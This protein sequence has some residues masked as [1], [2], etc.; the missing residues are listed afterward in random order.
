M[1]IEKWQLIPLYIGG[2]DWG[3]GHLT[4]IVGTGD[5][6][7]RTFVHFFSN[8]RGLLRSLRRGGGECSP[9]ELTRTLGRI[10]FHHSKVNKP[11]P[12]V[13]NYGKCSKFISNYSESMRSNNVS[14]FMSPQTLGVNILSHC[15]F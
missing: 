2:M 6:Q 15:I 14:Q 12:A 13:T 11:K 10:S 3:P 8:A 4:I 9:L 5:P 1:F 7:G